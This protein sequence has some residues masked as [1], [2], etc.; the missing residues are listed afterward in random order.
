[1]SNRITKGEGLFG[2][3]RTDT[4]VVTDNATIPELVTVTDSAE[5]DDLVVNVSLTVNGLAYAVA[6]LP[7]AAADLVGRIVYDA[8]T[9]GWYGCQP[10]GGGGYEW[11]GLST[12]DHT[13]D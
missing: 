1:M 5:L 7:A 6:E 12:A 9:G 13:H 8:D 10:D 11:I 3:V 4:L 2:A